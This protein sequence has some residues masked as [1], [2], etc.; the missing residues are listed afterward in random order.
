MTTDPFKAIELAT[1]SAERI[2]KIM[3][4]EKKRKRREKIEN[5]LITG[6]L[7]IGAGYLIYKMLKGSKENKPLPENIEGNPNTGLS[8]TMRKKAVIWVLLL[9]LSL[10]FLTLALVFMMLLR[11]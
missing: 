4:E 3:K 2:Y 6:S 1:Q 5:M 10:N 7:A 9:S 11:G 8:L